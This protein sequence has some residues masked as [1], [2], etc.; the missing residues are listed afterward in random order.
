VTVPIPGT[1]PIE[2]LEESLA[3][4]QIGLTDDE[5]ERLNAG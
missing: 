1:S 2:H 4:A 5:L 3:A